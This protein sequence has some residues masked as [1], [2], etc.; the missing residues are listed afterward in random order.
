MCTSVL[1]TSEIFTL[2]TRSDLLES[3][4]KLKQERGITWQGRFAQMPEV[5]SGG[6]TLDRK[7]IV[8]AMAKLEKQRKSSR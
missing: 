1:S 2:T 7:T 6:S 3:E 8:K 4:C 5:T